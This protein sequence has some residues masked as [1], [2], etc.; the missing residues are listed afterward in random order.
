[1]PWRDLQR[2]RRRLAVVAVLIDGLKVLVAT[3][4]TANGVE[5]P[6]RDGN[7]LFQKVKNPP[8][9]KNRF[10]M[11]RPDGNG[12]WI[13]NTKGI[14]TKVLY[15]LF[16]IIEAMAA[17]PPRWHGWPLGS[18]TPSWRIPISGSR[19]PSCPS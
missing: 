16:E 4:T 3:V 8:S 17:A 18:R 6:A 9:R 12:G 7:L 13:Y 1:M 10:L 5:A 2:S 15:R 19:P 11:R 14:N